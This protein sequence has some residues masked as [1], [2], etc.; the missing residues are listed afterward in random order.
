MASDNE[1][2]TRRKVVRDIGVGALSVTALGTGSVAA[3]DQDGQ[4][5]ESDDGPTVG[6]EAITNAT[7]KWD[8]YTVQAGSESTL[9]STWSLT[10]CCWS[11]FSFDILLEADY[12]YEPELV[13]T[14]ISTG[15]IVKDWV[16][17]SNVNES[18]IDGPAWVFKAKERIFAPFGTQIYVDSIVDT[19]S[20]GTTLALTGSYGVVNKDFSGAELTIE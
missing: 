11:L 13:A 15:S 12:V 8:P 2:V 17:E 19:Y 4:T 3:S 18:G 14:N 10:A 7:T 9:Q 6:T 16:Y 20:S 5:S 1:E